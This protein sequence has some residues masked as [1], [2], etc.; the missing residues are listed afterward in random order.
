MA[1]YKNGVSIVEGGV[2]AWEKA[3]LA[4]EGGLNNVLSVP[5]DVYLRAYDREDPIEVEKAM[6]EYLTWELGLVEQI[7][8]PGGTTFEIFSE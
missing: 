3:G 7:S 1:K 2:A 6:N 5:N 8:R 4:L